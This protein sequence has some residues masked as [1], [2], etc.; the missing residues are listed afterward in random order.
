[1]QK[2][3]IG[4]MMVC[5]MTVCAA[6]K[7]SVQDTFLFLDSGQIELSGWWGEQLTTCYQGRMMKQ[8]IPE[9]IEPFT[10]RTEKKVWQSE[11]WGKWF[12][13]AM[14]A[15]HYQPTPELKKRLDEA[16]AELLKT[17]TA[18][19]YIGNYAPEAQT[20]NWDIWGRKYVLL[21]LLAYYDVTHDERVLKAAMA[22]ADY[23]YKQVVGPGGKNIATCGCWQGMA[24]SS[25]LEPITLLYRVTGEARYLEFAK[26]IVAQMEGEKGPRLVQKALDKVTVYEM[27]P[28]PDAAKKGY[29]SGGDSKAYEMMSCY[30]GLL[31]LYRT[32]GEKN[33]LQAALNVNAD[34]AA[35]EMTV[36]GSGS[37]WERWN[38]GR[39]KQCVP[40]SFWME[41]CVAATWIKFNAQLLRLTGDAQYVDRIEQCAYNALMASQKDD[42]TGWAHYN[43]LAGIRGPAPL[44]CN[45]NMN[46]CVASGPRALMLLPAL[47]VMQ[48]AEGV[49]VNF[50]NSGKAKTGKALLSIAGDYPKQGPVS[51]A[52]DPVTETEW[53]LKLRIPAW[54]RK[55]TVTINGKAIEGA[56]AGCYLP[57]RRVW[58]KGDTIALNVDYSTYRV[59]DPSG[60]AHVCVQRGPVILTLDRRLVQTHTN[61][62]SITIAADA[63]DVIAARLVSEAG[64][65]KA[66]IVLDIPAVTGD[67]K[68]CSVRLCDY[69]SAG[70]PWGEASGYRVWLPQPIN[71]SA[72]FEGVSMTHEKH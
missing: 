46:C 37:S 41:T 50:Y 6:V 69:A 67:G 34:I 8:S 47:A 21:G 59:K 19:G 52:L 30:E 42:G 61:A 14:L 25:I 29:S 32:T 44:H 36:L 72:P 22:E 31:E 60:T 40:V 9:L 70:N 55:T 45:M 62:G 17:Q 26:G 12:T 23:T 39:M 20:S 7:P 43:P 1:M 64:P 5:G 63:A 2:I 56:V 38:S 28:K 51:I 58:K 24:A 27:F 54:S 49:V 65:F 4:L 13:S 18:D 71:L 66:N 10:K 35:T 15:Y 11:F 57:I 48:D 16:V 68:P 3:M 33:F 53:T